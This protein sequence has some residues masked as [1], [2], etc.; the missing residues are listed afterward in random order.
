MTVLVGITKSRRFNLHLQNELANHT[1][2]GICMAFLV[3]ALSF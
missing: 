2:Q 3:I 1:N